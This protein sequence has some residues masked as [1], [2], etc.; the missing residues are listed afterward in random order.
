MMTIDASSMNYDVLNAQVREIEG[1][2]TLTGVCG[3]RFI[4]AGLSG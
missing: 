1:D 3:Q 2:V 4:G